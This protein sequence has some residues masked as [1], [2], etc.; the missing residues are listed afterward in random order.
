MN[1]NNSAIDF[2]PKGSMIDSIV[3]LATSGGSGPKKVALANAGTFK[4]RDK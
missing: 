2:Y 1:K 4:K 3:D